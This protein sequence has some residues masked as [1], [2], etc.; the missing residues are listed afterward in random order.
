MDSE[1]ESTTAHVSVAIDA[2]VAEV[3][4]FASN[5]A[6]LP[7]WAT[8]LGG[9]IAEENGLWVA[10]SPLGRIVVEFAGRNSLGVLDHVVTT[11]DGARFYNPLR[12]TEHGP[13]SEIV[14]S[15]RRA[16]G[17]SEQEFQA[18]RA[19]I[20]SDLERLKNIIEG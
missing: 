10:D 13:G 9:S 15:L 1:T 18:D 4:D 8:G 6:N 5:P 14:F 11:V 3:Y 20:R 19:T 16:P 2:P 7:R 17:V 12:V